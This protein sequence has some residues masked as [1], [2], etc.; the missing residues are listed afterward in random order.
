MGLVES[1]LDKVQQE[2]QLI[3]EKSNIIKKVW[4]IVKQYGID[5]KD[6]Y[7]EPKPCEH[8]R[9]NKS[10]MYLLHGT[11][12]GYVNNIKREGLKIEKFGERS[13]EDKDI[14]LGKPCIWFSTKASKKKPGFGGKGTL[15]FLVAKVNTKNINKATGCTYQYFKNI[16]SKDIVW[17]ND[18]RFIQIIKSD[19][20]LQWE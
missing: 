20:C 8:I 5:I 19:P 17:E 9:I 11:K 2:K 4:E 14:L 7:I 18:K 16:P 12:P 13:K 3:L 10:K 6:L 15:I 1:Y